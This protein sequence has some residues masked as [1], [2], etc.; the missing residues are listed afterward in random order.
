MLAAGAVAAL[1]ADVPF[2]HL[3]GLH[4]VV[5]RMAAGTER[6]GRARG[7]ID[8]LRR[9]LRQPPLGVWLYVIGAPCPVDDIPL[10]V[11]WIVIVTAAKEVP[12]LPLRA[13]HERHV[14]EPEIH[15]RV[16]FAEISDDHARIDLWIGNDIGHPR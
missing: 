6:T 3:L 16:R 9:A 8:R 10:R 14:L 4:V 11:G 5:R 13:V 2:G 15:Q 7:V 1:A 12:L